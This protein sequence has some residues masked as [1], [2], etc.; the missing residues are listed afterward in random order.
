MYSQITANKR[1]TWGLLIAFSILV[2]GLTLILGV[3]FGLHPEEALV[4][5]VAF[6]MIYSLISYYASASVALAAAG[7][8]P[9]E[10]RDH[11]ALYTTVENLAITAGIP[12]PKIYIINDP[13][14]NAFAT[15]RDPHHAS[16]AITTGLLNILNKQELEGVIAHELSHIK[17]YDIRVMTIVVVLIGL[18]VLLSDMLFRVGFIR[19][20]DRDRGGNQAAI[21]FFIIGLL[22]AI[23]AP[24]IAQM[25]KFA[26]SRSREYLADASGALLTRYPA[27][28]ASALVNIRD[29]GSKMKH[30]NHATAHLYISSPFGSR[31]EQ[32]T[33]F[34]NRLFATHPPIEDRIAELQK[35]GK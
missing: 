32:K 18:I 10:K 16:V 29:H 1:K 7:A 27:G 22:A 28:L 11:F 23:L 20:N 21:V 34:I 4:F 19:G 14:P 17:N 26:V 5:G 31:K 9:L 33:N 15:G 24:L 25:I 13:S 12:T 6:S 2:V 8:K 3:S 30:A 35:M